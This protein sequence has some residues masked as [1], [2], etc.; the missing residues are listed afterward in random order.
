MQMAPVVIETTAPV[1][2][3]VNWMNIALLVCV[4]IAL[5]VGSYILY[6]RYYKKKKNAN[7]A[8]NTNTASRNRTNNTR[9][10]NTTAAPAANATADAGLDDDFGADDFGDFDAPPQTTR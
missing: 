10:T 6:T 9:R 5:G 2:Q 3:G 4:A 8:P 1:K 7:N